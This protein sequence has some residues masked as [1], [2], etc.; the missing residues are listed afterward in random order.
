MPD[1]SKGLFVFGDFRLDPVR[2]ILE[3]G[4][5]AVPLTSKALETLLVL[6]RNRDRVLSKDELMRSLWPDSFVEEVNLAQNVSAVR[7]ALGETPGENRYIAT[8]PGR[9][10][11]FVGEVRDEGGTGEQEL[12]LERR[13]RTQV[14]VIEESDDEPPNLPAARQPALPMRR[15]NP[16]IVALASVVLLA[17]FSVIGWWWWRTRS[18]ASAGHSLAVLPFQPLGGDS[19]N[20][21]LGLGIAD[22]VITKLS[23][24]PEL[25]VRPTDV[26]VRYSDSKVDPLAAARELGVDS[27]LSGKIQKSG[28]RLR[29]TVQL[30][31]VSNGQPLWA[32]TYDEDYTSIFGIE[33]SISEQVAQSL[34][35]HLAAE[36]RI[37][38]KRHY[39]DNIEAY[40]NYLEGLYGEFAFTRDG[41]NQ[42][43]EHFNRAIALDPS[44]ALA[45]AGLA[46]AYT[47][48]S[49]WLLAPR[50][51]LPKA[52]AA[53]RKALVFD[54]NLAE[55]HGALAHA[56]LHEWQLAESER[57]F[58]TA[59]ALNP[60]SVSTYFAWAE[61]LV[62]THRIDQGI[63][64]M[65]KAL[66]LDPLS[67]EIN[68]F[69]AWDYYLKRDYAQCL[70]LAQKSEQM[71]PDFWVPYM[72]AGM[73]HSF[74]GNYQAGLDE[75]QKSLRLDPESTVAQSGIGVDLALLGKKA[76]ALQALKQL[77]AMQSTTYVSPAYVSLVYQ[78]LGDTDA[79]FASLNKAYDDQGEWLLWL[80]VD[81]HYDNQRNDPRLCALVMKVGVAQH[82]P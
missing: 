38:I 32:Q 74:Q 25:P 21:H 2:R 5:Q 78:A 56:L 45:Y 80:D 55:A 37:R 14:V 1:D 29:V 69:L 9:G 65:Q 73:C 79:E 62:S 44:Y 82:C 39:T 70:V 47:T 15:A 8:I 53:A 3:R 72:M 31:H 76:E 64:A 52:E 66:T 35:L 11:R 58:H 4:G 27:V 68:S 13:T 6:V 16:T 71:F 41:M 59:L 43:V 67:P 33:D 22:A 75:L 50:D 36:D 40:R 28:Q 63:A 26:A 46:D 24:Y 30:L 23:N 54:D 10:Y 34:A 12:V 7:K 81:P 48:E 77:Q 51:A 57:E 42:A 20:D 17:V 60:G 19:D 18:T 49:D 61:L